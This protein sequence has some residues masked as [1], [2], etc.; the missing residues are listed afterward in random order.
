MA[1]MAVSFA[2]GVTMFPLVYSFP[3]AA[4]DLRS[5]LPGRMV[6]IGRRSRFTPIHGTSVSLQPTTVRVITPEIMDILFVQYK[7]SPRLR[8]RLWRSRA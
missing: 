1:C 7:I 4:V 2:V 3:V 5:V 8:Y 6:T